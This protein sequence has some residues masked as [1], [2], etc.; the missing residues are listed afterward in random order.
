MGDLQIERTDGQKIAAYLAE[1]AGTA[2]GNVVVIQEWW[3]LN[4]QI[5]KVCDRYAAE[6]YRALAP[7]LFKGEIAKNAQEA[8]HKMQHL[9]FGEAVSQ[10]IAGAVAFLRKQPG[11]VAVTGF[12]MGGALTILAAINLKIDAAMCFYGIPPASAADPS[13]IKVAF[14]GHFAKDDDW[15]NPDVVGKLEGSLKSGKVDYQ[16]FTYDAKHAFMNEARPEVYDAAVA[17]Q[18]WERTIAFLEKNFG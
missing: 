10:D 13:K 18:A 12:C 2:K 14:I 16:L 6:G 9:N 15:C 5:K 8:S 17:K 1:P 3:G 4:P 11:K 7:D